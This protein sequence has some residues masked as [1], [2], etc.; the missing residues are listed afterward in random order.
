MKQSIQEAQDI[1]AERVKKAEEALKVVQA[2]YDSAKAEFKQLKD[3]MDE[4]NK[5]RLTQSQISQVKTDIEKAKKS[6][7]KKGRFWF[8]DEVVP[9]RLETLEGMYVKA[10]EYEKLDDINDALHK[11]ERELH[12]RESS[13]E[14]REQRVSDRERAVAAPEAELQARIEAEKARALHLQESIYKNKAQKYDKVVEERDQFRQQ[15][16]EYHAIATRLEIGQGISLQ[17][18]IDAVEQESSEN[19]VYSMANKVVQV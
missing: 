15:V 18:I 19:L 11:R 3:D 17:N 14:S 5:Y 9:V 8:G 16:E 13:L 10:A 1:A 6:A 7:T 2:E 12:T 4:L